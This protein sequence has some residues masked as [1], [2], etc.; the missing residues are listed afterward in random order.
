MASVLFFEHGGDAGEGG[1]DVGAG[2]EGA[3][4]HVAFA[5]GAEAGAGGADD[6]GL[7]EELVE[8]GPGIGAGV[9]PDVGGVVAADA[10]VA[11]AGHGVADEF[12]VG[13]V[14]GDLLFDLGLAG[15]GVY[16]GGGLLHGV[17]DA[18]ELGRVAAVPEGVHRVGRAGGVEGL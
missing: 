4:A 17:G 18:V 14:V 8:E 11:E 9:D 16:G 5:A 10:A 3:D 1:L 7:V 12:R 2:V 13:H 15:L 6:L